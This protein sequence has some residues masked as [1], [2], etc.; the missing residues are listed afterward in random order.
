MAESSE[1][2]SQPA[3]PNVIEVVT[4]WARAALAVFL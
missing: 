1:A 4:E 2:V 3:S